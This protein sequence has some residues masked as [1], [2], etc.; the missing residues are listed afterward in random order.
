M[1]SLENL[2]FR[3]KSLF[4]FE[5]KFYI[6]VSI[7]VQQYTASIIAQKFSAVKCYAK[8]SGKR[9]IN[10]QFALD[11]HHDL[12]YNNTVL[13]IKGKEL[14]YDRRILLYGKILLRLLFLL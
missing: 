5:Y 3:L 4:S 12:V 1:V 14:E 2:I 6:S 13:N 10:F 9:C 11:K 8:N 7:I